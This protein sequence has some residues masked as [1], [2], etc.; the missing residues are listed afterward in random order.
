MRR[1]YTMPLAVG[2]RNAAPATASP[3]QRSGEIALMKFI[4]DPGLSIV[5]ERRRSRATFPLPL[6][7]GES[8][9]VGIVRLFE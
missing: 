7:R 9:Y 2:L 6:V 1:V 5:N 4:F 8:M 3:R